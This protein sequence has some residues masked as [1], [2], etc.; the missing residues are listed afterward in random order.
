MYRTFT[1]RNVS[2]MAGSVAF[3]SLL[4]LLVLPFVVLSAVAL[5]GPVLAIVVWPAHAHGS[6]STHGTRWPASWDGAAC[7]VRQYVHA[8]DESSF[9][10]MLDSLRPAVE[11][12]PATESQRRDARVRSLL[13][14]VANGAIGGVVGTFAMTAYRLPLFEGLPPTAEFWAQYV[15]DDDPSAYP[16]RALALH[17]GYGA[18][19]GSLLGLALS[20]LGREPDDRDDRVTLLAG[21]GYALALSA[22]GSR[23]LLDRTL[24]LDLSSD[25]R[26][27]FHVGH[28]VYG[29]ALGTW[30]GAAGAMGR[31]NADG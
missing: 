26:M 7:D 9:T 6:P 28:V 17:F 14:T 13:R 20:R 30:L 8:A 27:V 19:A 15:G 18:A 31:S 4:P 25:E 2:S 22:F 11:D 3:F 16:A 5:G 12:R 24:D 23:V 10:G 21:V 29:L 1:E